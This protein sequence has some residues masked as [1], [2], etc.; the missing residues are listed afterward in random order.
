MRHAVILA[1]G[2]GTRLWPA[3]RGGR[4][5]QYL[6]LATGGQV[7]LAAAMARGLR[8]ADGTAVVVTA[9]AQLPLAAAAI[10]DVAPTAL[11][12]GEPAA[13]NTAA[14]I[15][16]AA[17]HLLDRDP[18]A[19]MVVLPADQAVADEAGLVA[20][21]AQATAVVTRDDLICTVGVVPTRAETGFGYLELGGARGTTPGLRDVARFV[22]KPDAATAARYVAGGGHLWNAGI[23]VLRAARVVAELAAR[24]P[25]IG[26][27]LARIAAALR[28]GPAAATAT[29]AEVY[30]T[31]PSISIDHAVMEHATGVVTLPA[32]VGWDD[33][34]SWQALAGRPL[35]AATAL[36]EIDAADNIVYVDDPGGDAAAPAPQVVALVG[37]SGLVVVRSGDALLVMP[38]AR[39]QDV[40]QV[41]DELKRRG[42]GRF[43]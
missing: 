3:S 42:L 18:D 30:P 36:V 12:L 28:Q 15:G 43:A 22:E 32:D 7:L 39:A 2:S 16:L 24:Q 11:L 35:D 1:G 34:G 8:V 38:R 20:L 10:A 40:R 37:V 33:I 17:V 14:A 31:L 6:P 13:R 19:V 41:V 23:F 9:A 5:K 27:G 4:P 26:A 25:T 21:L 29:I